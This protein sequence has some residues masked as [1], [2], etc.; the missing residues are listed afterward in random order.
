MVF[1]SKFCLFVCFYVH[2]FRLTWVVQV[3]V[4]ERR[5]VFFRG[6]DAGRRLRPVLKRVEHY[7]GRHRF[8]IRQLHQFC[9]SLAR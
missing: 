3:V 7:P 2:G 1:L 8:A 4:F 9:D 6:F 5:S